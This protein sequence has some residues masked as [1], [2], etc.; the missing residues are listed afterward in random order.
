MVPRL[1]SLGARA[2]I[3][4]KKGERWLPLEDFFAAPGRTRL[5]PGEILPEVQIPP[6]GPAVSRY[7][8]HSIRNAMDLAVVGVAAGS[9]FPGKGPV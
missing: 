8:K 1:I 7:A 3:A 5:R 6:S 9:G 2:K 4:G